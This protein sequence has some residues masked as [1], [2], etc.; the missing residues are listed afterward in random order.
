M[1]RCLRSILS[2]QNGLLIVWVCSIVMFWLTSAFYRF[3]KHLQNPDNVVHVILLCFF[4]HIFVDLP[5]FGA[6]LPLASAD[7]L[8]Y[9]IYS[10]V[11]D[12]ALA[13]IC[14]QINDIGHYY[15]HRL[16]HAGQLYRL[17]K[18]HHSYTC[19]FAFTALWTHPIEHALDV[20]IFYGPYFVM[21]YLFQW[22]LYHSFIV[23]F[24]LAVGGS[25]LSVRNHSLY[26]TFH[27]DH[28]TY[29]Q[30]FLALHF[31]SYRFFY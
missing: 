10:W 16:C 26:F 28:H 24:I 23:V 9:N 31:H 17:H 14:L 5:L 22:T 21:E 19:N 20:I 13:W 18:L 3:R 11:A 30:V 4:N 6:L 2:Y 8:D 7:S 15:F 1:I 12:I 27:G 29:K 25:I